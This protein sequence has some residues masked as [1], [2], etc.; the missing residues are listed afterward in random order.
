MLQ[1]M[2]MNAAERR[3]YLDDDDDNDDNS[4]STSDMGELPG[5][6]S[7]SDSSEDGEGSE[8]ESASRSVSDP[9]F[10]PWL[11]PSDHE[12]VYPEPLMQAQ[13][14]DHEEEAPQATATPPPFV[15]DG[16]G[17]VV[18]SSTEDEDKAG[19][20]TGTSEMESNSRGGILGWFNSLF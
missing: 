20:E 9:T 12:A 4:G 3:D 6:Q 10:M 7:V 11:A 14:P 18:W 16:R 17:R 5:L 1:N 8:S 19:D 13:V 15:T 2:Q